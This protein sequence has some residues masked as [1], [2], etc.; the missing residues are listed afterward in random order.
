MELI[1]TT[2]VG[3]VDV[4]RQKKLIKNADSIIFEPQA[5]RGFWVSGVAVLGERQRKPFPV[6]RLGLST[7]SKNTWE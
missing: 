2:R 7:G 3:G 6:A 1:D 5:T 4:T